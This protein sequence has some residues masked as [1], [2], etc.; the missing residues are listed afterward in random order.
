MKCPASACLGDAS[1]GVWSVEGSRE[2]GGRSERS[3]AHSLDVDDRLAAHA[4]Q[5]RDALAAATRRARR[6][7]AHVSA[8]RNAQTHARVKDECAETHVEFNVC[9]VYTVHNTG[10]WGGEIEATHGRLK[11]ASDPSSSY[12]N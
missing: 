11:D 4:Q 5:P 3:C 1:I 12:T 9:G 10:H 8:R 6:L 7:C 2:G